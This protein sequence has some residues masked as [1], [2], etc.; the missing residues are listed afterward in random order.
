MMTKHAVI[1]TSSCMSTTVVFKYGFVDFP[2]ACEYRATVY[3]ATFC[4]MSS[5]RMKTCT[6]FIGIPQRCVSGAG[7]LD[8]TSP[9][10]VSFEAAASP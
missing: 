10:P 7:A 3:I 8:L 1:L 2:P 9:L 4:A 6:N 5:K